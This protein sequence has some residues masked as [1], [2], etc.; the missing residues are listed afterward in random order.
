MVPKSLSPL[1]HANLNVLGR[2]TSR[3]SGPVGEQLRPLRDPDAAGPDED[4]DGEH[5]APEAGQGR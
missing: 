4:D 3:D 1:S 2:Y 5:L